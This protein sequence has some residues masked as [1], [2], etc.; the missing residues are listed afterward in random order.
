MTISCPNHFV[1][2]I[3]HQNA[4]LYWQHHNGPTI[5]KKLQSHDDDEQER[6]N[7]FMIQLPH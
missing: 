5:D 1:V 7:I 6:R 4:T 2:E 3:F